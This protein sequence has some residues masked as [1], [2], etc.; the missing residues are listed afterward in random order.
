ML[1][2]GGACGKLLDEK[3]AAAGALALGTSIAAGNGLAEEWKLE[4][5][6]PSGEPAGLLRSE[7]V[8]GDVSA[9]GDE[10]LLLLFHPKKLEI[11]FEVDKVLWGVSGPEL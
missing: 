5:D 8:V 2:V 1:G 7:I 3:S 6:V 10:A 4:R 11:L 9:I